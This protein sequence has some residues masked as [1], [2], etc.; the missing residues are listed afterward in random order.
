[1]PL[2]N[3]AITN[4]HMPFAFKVYLKPP[5]G[6]RPTLQYAR[7]PDTNENYAHHKKVLDALGLPPHLKAGLFQLYA[8]YR[9]I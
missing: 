3:I 8:I 9:S 4:S 6:H 2:S 5:Q 1:M 7:H